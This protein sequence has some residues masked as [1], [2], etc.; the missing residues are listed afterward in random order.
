M[1]FG[2]FWLFNFFSVCLNLLNEVYWKKVGFLR[3]SGIFL[4]MEVFY[5]SYNYIFGCK[6]I[7]I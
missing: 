2:N 1:D 7:F 5:L 6:L 4:D 3:V